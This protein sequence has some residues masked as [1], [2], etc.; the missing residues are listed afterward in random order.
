MEPVGFDRRRECSIEFVPPYYPL[1]IGGSLSAHP[2]DF[3]WERHLLSMIRDR[4]LKLPLRIWI[5]SLPKIFPK[6]VRATNTCKEIILEEIPNCDLRSGGRI[7]SGGEPPRFSMR[8]ETD[9]DGIV[10]RSVCWMCQS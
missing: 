5:S 7:H 1:D 2:M 10:V 4:K 3:V 6:P 9:E 8:A